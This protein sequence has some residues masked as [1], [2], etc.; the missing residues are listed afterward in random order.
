MALLGPAD[1]MKTKTHFLFS[2]S[3]HFG[4]SKQVNTDYIDMPAISTW[5]DREGL[6]VGDSSVYS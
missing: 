5:K 6:H 4:D 1:S 2:R 3:S